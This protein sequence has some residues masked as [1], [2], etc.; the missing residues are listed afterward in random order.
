MQHS[1]L[2]TSLYA[3][4]RTRLVDLLHRALLIEA[5]LLEGREIIHV[6]VRVEVIVIV[7]RETE[8]D[9]AVDARREGRRL[10]Q[11]EARRE[12][13][14]VIQQPDEVLDRLV[15]LVGLRLVAPC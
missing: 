15:R 12:E 7:D 13:R 5:V 2:A 14:R 1:E 8:L 4:K 11:R 10:V 6:V 3:A 9:E